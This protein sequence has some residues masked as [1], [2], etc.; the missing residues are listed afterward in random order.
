M[1][2]NQDVVVSLLPINSNRK[3]ESLVEPLE[4]YLSHPVVQVTKF[5]IKKPR[6]EGAR[7]EEMAY[8]DLEIAGTVNSVFASSTDGQTWTLGNGKLF[9]NG[10]DKAVHLFV[11]LGKKDSSGDAR[12]PYRGS[13]SFTAEKVRVTDGNN[14]FQIKMEDEVFP[15]FGGSLWSVGFAFPW[16]PEPGEEPDPDAVKLPTITDP[17]THR[18]GGGAG[19]GQLYTVAVR[20][21]R[22][23]QADSARLHLGIDK[24][25]SCRLVKNPAGDGYLAQSL[26]SNDSLIVALRATDRKTGAEPNDKTVARL[27]AASDFAKLSYRS[28]FLHS[29]SVGLLAGGADFVAGPKQHAI[30]A[31]EVSSESKAVI[32]HAHLNLADG[33]ILELKSPIWPAAGEVK[34]LPAGNLKTAELLAYTMQLRRSKDPRAEEFTIAMLVGEFTDLGWDNVRAQD[35]CESLYSTIAETLEAGLEACTE[36]SATDAGY[37]MGRFVGEALRLTSDPQSPT[38]VDKVLKSEFLPELIKAR[39]FGGKVS[40]VES[41]IGKLKSL[42]RWG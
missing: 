13:F 2:T 20:G 42:F 27:L 22:P 28:A 41:L 8:C 23:E 10:D 34:P 26:E 4:L 5:E 35:W 12:R 16:P 37:Y 21:I 36:S 31:V 32:L 39:I 24:V 14:V 25:I 7:G 19:E 30:R 3:P 33:S 18:S 29:Y 15:F 11:V 17:P 40:A 38:Q 9:V 1:A 6:L